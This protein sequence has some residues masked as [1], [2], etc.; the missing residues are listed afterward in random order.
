M[1]SGNWERR[2]LKIVGPWI[3]SPPKIFR[4]TFLRGVFRIREKGHPRAVYLTFDDG[5][6]PE[7]TPW[8][9]DELD[10]LGVKA[11]FFVVGDNV[12]KYPELYQEILKRGHKTG[13]HTM[14]H[15]NG[16]KAWAAKYIK[17]CEEAAEYVDSDLMRPPHGWMRFTPKEFLNRKYRIIMYDVVTR[18]YSRYVDADRVFENVKRYARPGSIIVFHDSKKSRAKLETALSQ[19]V[20]WLRNQGYEFR[21]VPGK[22]DK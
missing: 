5:P 6:I 4:R 13:N 2:F 20:E 1:R 21:L 7:C 8:L 17:D 16:A 3:E 10:R 9:L 11:T 18:D 22:E 14:H 19:S 15:L 12:R